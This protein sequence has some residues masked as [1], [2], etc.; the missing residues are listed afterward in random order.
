MMMGWV[1]FC[2]PQTDDQILLLQNCWS[3]LMA[4][5]LCWRSI[6]T[7]NQISISSSHHITAAWAHHLGFEDV[8]IQLINITD[9]FRR[10]FMDQ[11]EYV[12]LKV[13]LLITPGKL[14]E[15]LTMQEF[16]GLPN[17]CDSSNI[18]LI[19]VETWV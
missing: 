15:K 9:C 17:G 5:S 3:E 4:L 12:A 11:F 18:S 6:D 16:I 8:V 2:F 13:L 14:K 7:P 19:I 1:C 10:L